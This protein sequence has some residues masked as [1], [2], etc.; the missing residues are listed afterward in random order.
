M[1]VLVLAPHPDDEV[2][3][4]GG[5]IARL[6]REGH[7][8]DVAIVTRGDE[9]FDMSL[10]ETGRAEA[11]RAHAILGVRKTHFLDGFPAAKLDTVPHHRLNGRLRD[12]V[13]D[14]RPEC[15][16]IP[17]AGDV[18]RDHQEVARAAM[19]ACRPTVGYNV[20]QIFAYETLSETNW[21]APGISPAFVP[22][23]YS[24][25]TDTIETKLEAMTAFQSQVRPFPHERSIEAIEHLARYRGATVSVAAAESFMLL[26]WV[27]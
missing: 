6:A 3:G 9:L 20:R 21:N 22:N 19:V 10:I 24:E 16:Y 4:V 8:V 11:R 18:H 13:S 2:L 5:T 1:N 7:A 12:L 26:R 17:F 27:R 23:V 25:I 15:V 14:V